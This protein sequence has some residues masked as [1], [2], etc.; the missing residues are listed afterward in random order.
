MQ[1]ISGLL[2]DLVLHVVWFSFFHICFRQNLGTFF[3]LSP[4]H[5]STYA[6]QMKNRAKRLSDSL[7]L[8]SSAAANPQRLHAL[9]I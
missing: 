6:I 7:T 3:V 1:Q 2:D 9:L 5:K 4:L 8:F